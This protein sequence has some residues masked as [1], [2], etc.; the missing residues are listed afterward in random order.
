M[1]CSTQS[2]WR[3]FHFSRSEF[4]RRK[5]RLRATLFIV[6]FI[7]ATAMTVRY[8]LLRVSSGEG[9]AHDDGIREVE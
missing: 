2:G 7:I 1:R 8:V 9:G 3:G 5:R 4:R 6:L